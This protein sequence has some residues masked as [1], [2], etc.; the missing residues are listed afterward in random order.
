[1]N[2]LFLLMPQL[3]FSVSFVYLCYQVMGPTLITTM[4]V[5]NLLQKPIKSLI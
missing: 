1:M 2:L 4:V 3:A 5:F